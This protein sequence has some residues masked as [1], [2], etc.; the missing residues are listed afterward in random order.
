MCEKTRD[1]RTGEGKGRDLAPSI[2]CEGAVTLPICWPTLSPPASTCSL[3]A[4]HETSP[5]RL[6][7]FLSNEGKIRE[8]QRKRN[9]RLATRLAPPTRAKRS[10]SCGSARALLGVC[11]APGAALLRMRICSIL[12]PNICCSQLTRRLSP[13]RGSTA[14]K[15]PG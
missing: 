7:S 3:P 10:C 12:R 2:S 13:K 14:F 5:T 9:G 6:F 11:S 8:R 4:Y 15:T 1:D